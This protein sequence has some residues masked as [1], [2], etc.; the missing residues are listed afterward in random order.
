MKFEAGERYSH[1]EKHSIDM[2]VKSVKVENEQGVILSVFWVSKENSK[3][4]SPDQLLIKT[5]DFEKW[6]LVE[7]S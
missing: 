7:E 2:L 6:K 3:V 5:E 1:S 4:L